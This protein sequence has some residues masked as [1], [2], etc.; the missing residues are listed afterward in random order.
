MIPKI[1]SHRRRLSMM[2]AAIFFLFPGPGVLLHATP[3]PYLIEAKK[4][5][6]SDGAKGDLFGYAIAVNGDTAV[7]GVSHAT[8]GT[9]AFQGAAYIF[10]RNTGGVDNWGLIKK[11]V[12]SDG[13]A[14]SLFGCSVSIKGDTL[15]VGAFLDGKKGP[16]GLGSAYIFE[17][18]AGGADNWGEVRKIKA[19]ESAGSFGYSVS[20]DGNTIAVGA[21]G[22]IDDV[23]EGAV[24]YVFERNAGGANNWGKTN[25]LS[26]SDDSQ[27]DFFA[28]EIGISGDTIVAGA[29]GADV[30]GNADQGAAYIFERNQG[31]PGNWGEVKKLTASDGATNDQLGRSVSISGDTIAVG[32]SRDDIGANVDQGSAYIF[33]RSQGGAGN[34]G[35]TKKVLDPQGESGERFAFAVALSGD[36]LVVGSPNSAGNRLLNRGKAFL[37]DRN[38]GGPDNWGEFQTV[39]GST[40]DSFGFSVATDGPTV[41]VGAPGE[42][43]GVNGG[44]GSASVFRPVIGSNPEIKGQTVTTGQ[45]RSGGGLL[46]TVGDDATPPGSLLVSVISAS[47]G[48]TLT[49]I[50]NEFGRIVGAATASCAVPV[51]SHSVVLQVTDGNGL[52]ATGN[53]TVNVTANAAPTLGTYPAAHVSLGG[54]TTV[55]P[56]APPSDDTGF[57]SIGVSAPGFT[58]SLSATARGD[59]TVNNAGPPGNYTVTVT[60]TD[61]CGVSAAPKT[62][63]MTVLGQTGLITVNTA[64]DITANDG[65]C[66]L[67]E[68]IVG[69][70]T[71]TASGALPGEC[72]AGLPGTDTIAF[73]IPGAGPHAIIPSSALPAITEPVIIDGLTQPGAD[74]TAWPPA[75]RIVLNGSN[76]GADANGLK[77]AANAIFSTIRGLA[78][79]QFGQSGI[80]IES[81]NNTVQANFLGTDLTGTARMGNGTG[82]KIVGG[83]T[84]LIGGTTPAARNLVSGNGTG[85]GL[86]GPGNRVQGNFIG[87]DVTGTVDLGN[88]AN[89]IRVSESFDSGA[90]AKGGSFSMSPA[91]PTALLD[92]ANVIGGSAPGAR[93]IISGNDQNGIYVTVQSAFFTAEGNF[94]GTDVTGTAPLGNNANGIWI[95]FSPFQGFFIG[96]LSEA[97]RN[98]ISANAEAGVKIGGNNGF[99]SGNLVW[100]NFIGTDVTGTASLGN[101]QDGVNFGNGASGNSVGL[102]TGSFAFVAKTGANTIAFNARDGVRVEGTAT[103][104]NISYNSIF[105]NAGLGINLGSD[106]VSAN[107]SGDT[108]TGPNGLQNFPVLTSVTTD[109]IA[110]TVQGIFSGKPNSDYILQFYSN[111]ATDPTGNGEGQ[112][113]VD[114]QVVHTDGGGN[115][116][117]ALSLPASV[118]PGKLF[119]ATATLTSSGDSEYFSTSEFSPTQV[120]EG[121][122]ASP[123]S[124]LLNI[125]TRLRVLS[126][127]NV[128]I[129]GLIIT[130]TEAKKVIIRGI[131][132][133]LAQFFNGTL[134]DPILELYQ[135]N[136][137]LETNNNWKD[138]QGAI[139]ATGIPP[140]HD[141]ESAIVRTL[142]PGA[143]T[144]ILRSNNNVPG[145]GLVEA[146]DLDQAADSKLAN[147][148]TRGFV[149]SGDNVMIGG[150]IIGNSGG[151][152]ATVVVRAIGPVLGNFGIVGALQDPTLDLVDANGVVLR[153]NDN[154]TNGQPTELEAL[155]LLPGDQREAA[156]VQTLA[157]GN[158]TAIVR[159][160]GNTTGVGLVEVYNVE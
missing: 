49:A 117:L 38:L 93:N 111:S 29:A 89:G 145:I 139:A 101:G 153:S 133:S 102:S 150:F 147:I 138:N 88:S 98:I 48:I 151:G 92:P 155:G 10:G 79:N 105:S 149:D 87:T 96:G 156:L 77:L 157:P 152:G 90:S 6:A 7:V 141:L 65:A 63:M 75:L 103:R 137:L 26:A 54:S 118:F 130:G 142:S 56:S 28:I 116:D 95:L 91:A 51:G 69:A 44:Q 109:G 159:G 68:A 94:I 134:D 84:S 136:T 160:A 74:G 108:D 12:A 2:G 15:V 113:W 62:F 34:W 124:Q 135:G 86:F 21:L 60:A 158:Y 143:Y 112:R 19:N 70:N 37:L 123:P 100:G 58:G 33:D 80:H 55:F 106:G 114:E 131:G 13:A 25:K 82:L 64:A 50:E 57:S 11:L 66:S 30:G 31:A 83:E 35:L 129:G 119:S 3:D 107:D 125:S 45:G 46:A 42:R 104:N 43:V 126:G 14:Q 41:A 85:I 121:I 146:Y 20:I 148:S 132:P 144:A 52:T 47:P 76:A 127:E 72:A 53:L 122:S 32:A 78:I 17:R 22:G 97:S 81:D 9:D 16:L 36:R 27:F 23:K 59:V 40:N 120:V 67:R 99:A 1:S 140:S 115:V 61:T 8:I 18:D 4:M 128:L 24:A 39:A 73:N 71:N 110:I 154:W 5:V